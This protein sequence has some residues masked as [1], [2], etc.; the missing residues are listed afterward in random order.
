MQV[1]RL[2]AKSRED[3]ASPC[4]HLTLHYQVRERPALAS[5]ALPSSA[6]GA[7][8]GVERR[9]RRRGLRHALRALRPGATT[10]RLCPR[11]RNPFAFER[12]S[13][14]CSGADL[15]ALH[16][17]APDCAQRADRVCESAQVRHVQLPGADLFHKLLQLRE[18]QG[19]LRVEDEKQLFTLRRKLEMKVLEA[20]DVSRLAVPW[21]T[22]LH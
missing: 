16:R 17:T 14:C 10:R 3:V 6:L 21:K 1:V 7:L 9:G 4:E 20:A 15:T 11:G 19:G 12:V 2:L 22:P 18:D 8:A 5:A 13:C